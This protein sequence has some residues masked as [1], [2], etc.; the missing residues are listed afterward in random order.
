LVA[1]G[2]DD[3]GCVGEGLATQDGAGR[4]LRGRTVKGVWQAGLVTRAGAG[5]AR[6]VNG[7]E[8]E[9][10][11]P[12]M[13][14]GEDGEGGWQAGLATRAMLVNGRLERVRGGTVWRPETP[15]E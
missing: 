5:G 4:T 8:G 14:L 10:R 9:G 1:W 2:T 3:E 15:R 13:T 7:V 12:G 11:R 6:T